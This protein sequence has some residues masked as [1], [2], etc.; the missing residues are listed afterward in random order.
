[1]RGDD[2]SI[3]P[4]VVRKKMGIEISTSAYARSLRLKRIQ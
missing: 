2:S 3:T 1:V 4:D